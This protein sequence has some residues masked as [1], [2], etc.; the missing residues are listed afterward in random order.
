LA[1]QIAFLDRG[2]SFSPLLSAD[3]VGAIG[4]AFE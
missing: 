4:A 3:G 1:E 2:T